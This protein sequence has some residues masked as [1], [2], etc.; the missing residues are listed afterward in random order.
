MPF[1]SKIG[2]VICA[3]S[4]TIYFSISGCAV[5]GNASLEKGEVGNM[6]KDTNFLFEVE[7]VNP[8]RGR[9]RN[10][11]TG[12]YTV[13][14]NGDTLSTYLPYIGRSHVAP[15]NVNEIGIKFTTHEFTYIVE[16][17]SDKEWR[18]TIEP[19]DI[20]EVQK[21]F[22]TIFTNGNTSLNIVSTHRDPITYRGILAAK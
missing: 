21:M 9:P 13:K 22:F 15:V 1:R 10:M 5:T 17:K 3:I 19:K 4:L 7:T 14:I 18:I 2:L 11:G 8:L 12:V 6:V 16:Q 20:S